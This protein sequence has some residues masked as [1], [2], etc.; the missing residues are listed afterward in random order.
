MGFVSLRPRVLP[1]ESLFEFFFRISKLHGAQA[2]LGRPD[3]QEPQRTR[4]DRVK[5]LHGSILKQGGAQ[6]QP[7]LEFIRMPIL[8]E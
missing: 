8:M 7:G 3:E 1:S 4:D 2:A 6:S 5:N